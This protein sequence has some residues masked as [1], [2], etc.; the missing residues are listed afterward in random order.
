MRKVIEILAIGLLSINAVLAETQSNTNIYTEI[1]KDEQNFILKNQEKIKNFTQIYNQDEDFLIAFISPNHG[2]SLLDFLAA[3]HCAKYKK[4]AYRFNDS[5]KTRIWK[6]F[7][8]LTKP[9]E[10]YYYECSEKVV[11]KYSLTNSQVR[12]TNYDD[13]SFYKYP[14]KHLFLYRKRTQ[15]F[16]KILTDAK[17][18]DASKFKPI[19]Y[20]VYYRDENEIHILGKKISHNVP[21]R[22]LAADHCAKFKKNVYFFDKDIFSGVRSSMLFYCTSKTFLFHPRTGKAVR[23]TNDSQ[24]FIEKKSPQK[25]MFKNEFKT[26]G[27]T[28]LISYYFFEASNDYLS[29]LEL[30]HRAYDLNVQADEFKAQI[31][32]N[33]NS[34]YSESQKLKSTKSLL[35]KGSIQIEAK[36]TD[37]SFVLSELGRGY[38]EQ[39]LPHAYSAA[40]NTVQLIITFK[41][42]G[43]D[44][45][46]GGKAAFLANFKE[47][48][49]IFQ[50]L[51]EINS[52]V[53]NMNST[54]KLVFGGAKEKKIRDK[55]NLNKALDEL[56]LY[57]EEQA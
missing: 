46:S 34:K 32:Y 38:Y 7:P 54:I 42:V 31:E 27:A 9:L 25:N 15:I 56:N 47:I 36:L 16:N 22:K 19:Y 13:K 6:N 8:S 44:I 1:S 33:K 39:S 5:D 2:I 17:K 24:Y 41:N 3:S 28:S 20:K 51:P 23:Y 45:K 10:A 48:V 50:A 14:D 55:G 26:Y 43:E 4:F 37:A 52:F 18:K 11:L 12:W 35:D 29:S 57:D 53:S 30:L 21:A 49:G 40:Q